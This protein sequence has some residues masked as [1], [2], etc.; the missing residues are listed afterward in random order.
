MKRA[1]HTVGCLLLIAGGLVASWYGATS[2][3]QNHNFLASRHH[4]NRSDAMGGLLL[5]VIGLAS[6]AT[7]LLKLS[8][9]GE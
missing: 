3:I 2:L 5:L 9:P 8:E 6:G 7:G 1:I 4:P